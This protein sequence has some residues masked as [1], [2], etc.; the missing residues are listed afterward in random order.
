MAGD[1]GEEQPE[2]RSRARGAAARGG[3]RAQVRGRQWRVLGRW[4]RGGGQQKARTRQ[5]LF[6]A[7]R[8][9]GGEG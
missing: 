6:R 7:G 8:T 2:K 5:C 9:C 1:E 3:L 4:S